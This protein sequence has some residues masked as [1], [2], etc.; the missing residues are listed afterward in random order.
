[1]I[2]NSKL[3]YFKMISLKL[4][5]KKKSLA[6]SVSQLLPWNRTAVSYPTKSLGTRETCFDA[7]Q[8]YQKQQIVIFL[9]SPTG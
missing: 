7:K 9:L 4:H 1:M 2:D 3:F 5:A 6:S 8:N